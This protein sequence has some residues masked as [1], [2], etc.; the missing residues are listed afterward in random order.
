MSLTHQDS[1]DVVIAGFDYSL[2]ATG[3]RTQIV[4][5]SGRTTTYA[6]DDLNR[7][8]TES[9]SD[10]V[11][12]DYSASYSYDTVGNRIQS[13]VDGV[14]TAFSYDNND[15]LLQ[16]GGTTYSYDD[17][18]NTLTETLDGSTKRFIYNA[19]NQLIEVDNA[20]GVTRYQYNSDGIRTGQTTGLET[21]GYVVDSN[22]DYAQVLQES[23]NGTEIVSYTYGDDLV[24]QTRQ[25]ETHHYHYDGLGSTRYLSDASGVLTDS[26]DYEAFGQLLNEAGSTENS[27]RFAGEQLDS[28]L[29]QYYLRA[30]YYNP[31][32]GRFTQMDSFAG[33]PSDPLTLHK[34]LYGNVDPVSNTDPSGYLT[35]IGLNINVFSGAS[36]SALAGG[37]ARVTANRSGAKILEKFVEAEL[38]RFVARYGGTVHRQVYFKGPG[39][40]RFAD[41]VVELGDRF[42]AIEVKNKIPLG[43]NALKRLAGQIKTFASGQSPKLSGTA[44]EVIVISEESAAAIEASFLAIEGKVATGTLSGVLQGTT[45]LI[46]VL[47][48]VL[49]GL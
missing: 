24:S 38:K 18:G 10:P 49:I 8:L 5:L 12:A 46:T 7:L 4:E 39:G 32:V 33:I 25:G 26:Y 35:L 20:G 22:R 47:R 23:V 1:S 13:V 45:G 42:V 6:Y 3:R 19:K 44:A 17:N 2:N 48:G 37:A 15:R 40:R 34:Y 36:F 41:A 29:D 43:G 27:Y 11:N 14:T 16:H 21:T 30:R 9:I 31:A 28:G